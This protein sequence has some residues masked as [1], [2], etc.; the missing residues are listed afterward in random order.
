MLFRSVAGLSWW[1]AG[2][3]SKFAIQVF[4]AVLVIACPCALGLAT[5]AAIMVAVGKG[6]EKG[7]LFKNA[8][9]LETAH[10]VTMAVFDKTGTIT[11]G[12]PIV[13]DVIGWNGAKEEAI[14]R[15]AAA[16]E[17]GSAHPLAVAVKERAAGMELPTCTDFRTTVMAQRRKKR[18]HRAIKWQI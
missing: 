17:Q 3:G 7:V 12:K 11:K 8:E 4:V 5:P 15:L 16:I 14:T 2:S 9:A 18:W 13:T 6:A 10:N 1:F